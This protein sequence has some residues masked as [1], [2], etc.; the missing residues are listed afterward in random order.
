MRKAAVL[1]VLAIVL[2]GC[3]GMGMILQGAGNGLTGH[4][5]YSRQNYR[6]YSQDTYSQTNSGGC[7]F[8]TECGPGQKCHKGAYSMA[9]VCG[10]VTDGYGTQSANPNARAQGCNSNIDCAYNASCTNNV[11]VYR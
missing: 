11:C 4:N 3:A 5:P 1:L 8:D 9:G 6:N 7:Q 2:N 10:V